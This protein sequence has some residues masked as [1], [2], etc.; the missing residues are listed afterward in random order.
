MDSSVLGRENA[1]RFGPAAAG[2]RPEADASVLR[3]ENASKNG[4]KEGRGGASV[5]S[6]ENASKIGASFASLQYEYEYMEYE[7][8]YLELQTAAAVAEVEPRSRGG[9]RQARRRPPAENSNAA[10]LQRVLEHL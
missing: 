2:R 10:R 8:D 6:R 9:D 4:A 1:S 5:L 3:R 7:Y